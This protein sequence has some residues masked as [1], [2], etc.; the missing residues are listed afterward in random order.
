MKLDEHVRYV[1]RMKQPLQNQSVDNPS[2]FIMSD[3]LK[4]ELDMILLT[5]GCFLHAYNFIKSFQPKYVTLFVPS[6]RPE[7]ISDIFNLYMTLKDRMPSNWVFPDEYPHFTFSQGH[8][9]SFA[10]QNHFSPDITV[11]YIENAETE[12]VYD[13]IVRSKH[14]TH[15]FSL[16]ITENIVK[17]LFYKKDFTFIHVPKSVTLYGGETFDSIV[18]K[19]VKYKRKLVP[20]DFE[21]VEDYYRFNGRDIPEGET[22]GKFEDDP[23]EEP[24]PEDYEGDVT[25]DDIMELLFEEEGDSQ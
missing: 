22:I 19:C 23:D 16:C 9:K 5:P 15:Y 7:F 1:G 3:S 25:D 6:L 2:I 13:L 18:E 12:R 17:E 10:Y 8:I 11:T 20:F 4:C 14:G 21:S 24:F